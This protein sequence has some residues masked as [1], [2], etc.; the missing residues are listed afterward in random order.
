MIAILGGLVLGLTLAL[1]DVT[2]ASV[3][4]R[5]GAEAAEAPSSL[6]TVLRQWVGKADRVGGTRERLDIIGP[7]PQSLDGN[8]MGRM[9]LVRYGAGL[10]LRWSKSG[11]AGTFGSESSELI[12]DD[13]SSF[14]LSYLASAEPEAGSE[15]PAADRVPVWKPKSD[16][17]RVLAVRVSLGLSIAG[18]TVVRTFVIAVPVTQPVSPPDALEGKNDGRAG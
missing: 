1:Q 3:V 18:E 6:E 5:T 2:R 17:G 13:V 15:K 8:G 4:L 11:P 9:S 16:K 7:L 10:A 12:A 14:S